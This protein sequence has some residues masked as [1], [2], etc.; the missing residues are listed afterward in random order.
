MFIFSYKYSYLV[1]ESRLHEPDAMSWAISCIFLFVEEHAYDTH[2][3]FLKSLESLLANP[4]G[5]M[6]LGRKAF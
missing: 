2:P 4:I 3:L 5:E 6:I 1:L